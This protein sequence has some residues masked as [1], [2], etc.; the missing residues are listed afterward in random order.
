MFHAIQ[1]PVRST[2]KFFRRVAVLWIGSDTRAYGQDGLFAFR[3]K[4]LANALSHAQRDVPRRVRQ[5]QREFIST[6]TSGRI[7]R[8]GVIS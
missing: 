3:G 7:N 8:A 2:Q 4:P 1:Y 6:V 5:Y